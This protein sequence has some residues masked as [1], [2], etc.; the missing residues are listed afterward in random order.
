MSG[1][2]DG[3]SLP[4]ESPFTVVVTE[5]CVVSAR[6]AAPGTWVACLGMRCAKPRADLN[7]VWWFPGQALGPVRT[8]E[9]VKEREK[10]APPVLRL[11]FPLVTLPGTYTVAH[12]ASCRQI[13]PS[14]ERAFGSISAAFAV[15]WPAL[16]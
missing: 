10:K 3:A 16:T 2:D 9:F 8:E 4:G 6:L 12:A 5:A 1:T 7:D 13:R 14:P 11:L 15:Q